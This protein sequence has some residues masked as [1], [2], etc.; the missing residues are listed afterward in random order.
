M[1]TQNWDFLGNG[2]WDGATNWS[3]DVL[4]AASDDVVIDVVGDVTVTHRMGNTV[5]N[6][7]TAQDALV[8]TGGLLSV[9]TSGNLNNFSLAGGTLTGA[10]TLLLDNFNWTGGAIVAQV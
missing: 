1:A 8:L 3:G 10:G 5:I 2:F 7:L 4:P 9:T 6:S